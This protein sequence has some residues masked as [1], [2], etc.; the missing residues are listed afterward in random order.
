MSGH[1]NHEPHH[2]ASPT[3]HVLQKLQL[4][5]YRPFDDEPDPRPVPEDDRVAGAIANIFDALISTLEDNPLRSCHTA[6]HRTFP[7]TFD[8]S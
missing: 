3:G 1:D 2:S 5:G 8:E 4:Y 7:S 6:A